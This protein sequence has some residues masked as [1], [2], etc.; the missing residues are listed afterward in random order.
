MPAHRPEF[1]E[2]TLFDWDIEPVAERSNPFFEASQH[3]RLSEASP[4]NQAALTLGVL[5]AVA[6]VGGCVLSM[7]ELVQLLRTGHF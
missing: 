1:G 5:L 3:A 7:M 6:F 2:T 4:R